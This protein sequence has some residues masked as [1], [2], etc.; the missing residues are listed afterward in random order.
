MN[1]ILSAALLSCVLLTGCLTAEDK[2]AKQAFD[3]RP[4]LGVTFVPEW[5]T[6][7]LVILRDV[8][9][10]SSAGRAGLQ[11]KDIITSFNGHRVTDIHSLNDLEVQARHNETVKIGFLRNQKPMSVDATLE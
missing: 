4:Q 3:S 5:D 6:E 8:P 9:P 1:R 10:D 2:A 7:N 11:P